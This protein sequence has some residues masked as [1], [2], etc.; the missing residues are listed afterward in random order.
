MLDNTYNFGEEAGFRNV[1]L[2]E[3]PKKNILGKILKQQKI[4]KFR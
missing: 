1:Q 2:R 3:G 4:I